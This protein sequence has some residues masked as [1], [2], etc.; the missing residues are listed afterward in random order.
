MP[1]KNATQKLLEIMRYLRTHEDGCA[2]TKSQT[3][4]SL[5]PYLVEESFE[6][7]DTIDNNKTDDDLRDE[8]GDVLLQIAFHA[9][10]AEERQSFTFDDVAQAIVDKLER[11]YP[12]IL[13]SEPNVLKTADEIAQRWEEVKEQERIKKGVTKDTS[14][15]DEISH[16]LPALVRTAKLKGRAAGAGWEWNNAEQL[17]DKV[18]EE[19]NELK[20]EIEA[21]TISQEKI[22]AEFGDLMF[23]MVDF[24]RW[25]GFDAEEALRTTNKR[26]EK[27]F[28]YM[29]QG[30]KR[31]GKDFKS[32]T[33]AESKALWEEIKQLEKETA[34]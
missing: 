13:G 11:R 3:H 32:A 1:A 15:L 20:A 14:I 22:M 9:Q 2:W 28:R 6:A 24:A 23:V 8:L 16:G 5:A 17:L 4:K 33:S 34:A 31:L 29:E 7:I 21:K 12:T 25:Y 30:L 26:F 18:F 27:R 10:I 19:I